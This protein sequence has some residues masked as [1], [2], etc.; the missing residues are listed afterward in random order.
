MKNKNII[1]DY[2]FIV[3]GSVLFALGVSAFLDP[4][5]ISPGGFTGIAAIFSRLFGIATGTVLLLL[6]IPLITVGFIKLGVNT[7]IKTAVS[8]VVISVSMDIFAACLPIISRD[9]IIC[10]IAG[11]TLIGSG[12]AMIFLHGGTSGGIDIAAKLIKL[13]Y[14]YFTM[15]RL[16]LLFDAAVIAASCAVYGDIETAL[17]AVLSIVISSAVIDKALCGTNGGKIVFIITETPEK[18]KAAIFDLLKRGISEISVLGGYTG[19]SKTMLV[20]AV[21]RRQLAELERIL[22]KQDGAFVFSC[23]ADE[24]IGN[25]FADGLYN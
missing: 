21:R 2:G 13:R 9:S 10:A 15:G 5:E 16:M 12:L 18:T 11:G 19:K 1:I 7:I 23:P 8:T 14:P 17:Y 3:I 22:R 25:G 4:A 6:N 24:I 20:C